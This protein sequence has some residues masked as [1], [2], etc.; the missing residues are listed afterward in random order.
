MSSRRVLLAWEL[1][2]GF[3]HLMPLRA[4]AQHLRDSGHRCHF[5]LRELAGAEQLGLHG[6][7]PVYAAPLAV[8]R[9]INPVKVQASYASLLHNCGFDHPDHLASRLRAWRQLLTDSGAEA[10]VIDHAP[11]ALLAARSLGLPVAATGTGFTLPPAESPLPAYPGLKLGD[12]VL[13]RNESQVLGTI[14]AALERFNAPAM[15]RLGALFDGVR[16]GLKTYAE[17]DHYALPRP[18]PYLGLPDLSEG[19]TVDWGPSGEKRL[20]AYLR[21]FAGLD[22]WL[23]ALATLPAQ[24]LVRIAELDPGRL[25]RYQRPGLVFVDRHVWLRQ[26]AETC[27]AFINYGGHGAT[28][29]MLLAGKPALLLPDNVERQLLARR[30]QQSGAALVLN[31][32]PPQA[33]A[34][35]LRQLLDDSR[36]HDAAARFAARYAGGGRSGILPTWLDAWL[37]AV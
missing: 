1:G 35:A 27:D 7:G 2:S 17:L 11:T 23:E 30:A 14:N 19:L 31:G 34:E 8:G 22:V 3:G 25:A 10:V 21:P 24:V 5:A 6:L 16:L 29:E 9:I 18:D 26:A 12:T 13:G 4:I 28:A 37:A 20:F 15:T 32:G 33:P 36:L